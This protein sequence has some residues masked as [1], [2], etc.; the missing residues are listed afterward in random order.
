VGEADPRGHEPVEDAGLHLQGE[1]AKI[2][3]VKA[4][5]EAALDGGQVDRVI[6]D[7]GMVPLHE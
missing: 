6:F 7:A 4:G 1:K 5:V 3:G 2:V